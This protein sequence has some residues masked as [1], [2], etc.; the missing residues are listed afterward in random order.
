M[1]LPCPVPRPENCCLRPF[2][3]APPKHIPRQ[4]RFEA[5][6]LVHR[7]DI[8]QAA[9]AVLRNRD[10]AEDLTQDVFYHAWRSFDRYEAGTNCRAWLRSILFHRMQ[11]H[12]RRAARGV[13]GEGADAAMGHLEAAE[14][15]AERIESAE[16]LAA[17]AA[18]PEVFRDVL[19]LAD[20][21][22][23][24][25]KEIAERLGIPAGTVMSRLSRARRRMRELLK[26]GVTR[27]PTCLR[28]A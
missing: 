2:L 12:R 17:L 9:L 22:E 26:D 19:L 13:L 8:F 14:P 1:T 6:A 23:C 7:R 18:L 4:R 3:V 21:E 27:T 20:V 16:M 25:Y 15:R 28:P 24:A 11:H 5:E 10:E